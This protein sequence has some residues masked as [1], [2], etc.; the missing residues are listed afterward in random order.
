MSKSLYFEQFV[1]GEAY[2]SPARTITEADLT[3]FSMMSGDWNPLHSDAVHAASSAFGRRVVHG[4]FGIALATGL[5][6]RIG[7]FD[8]SAIALLDFR[9]WR[10]SKPIFIGDTLHVALAILALKPTKSGGRGVIDRRI[11]LINQDGV[12]VQ[13]GCSAILVAHTPA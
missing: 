4:A 7:I 1:V 6:T 8:E 10:F 2:R 9:E 12:T 3:F 11:A 13:D 5:I